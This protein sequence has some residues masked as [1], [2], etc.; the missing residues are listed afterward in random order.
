[1]VI[2]MKKQK[3]ICGMTAAVLTLGML[4]GC[5][6]ADYDRLLDQ[7]S[8]VTVTVWHYYNGVQ[9]T[10][11]DEMVSRFNN[12]VGSEKGIY[13][14]AFSKNSVS[15]LSGSVLAAVKEEP[16]A[17]NAPNIFATYVETAYQVDQLGKLADLGKYF[18][19]D[20]K[21]EYIEEY[22]DEGTFGDALVIF[23][24]AKC[25]EVMM[26][27]LT[28]WEGFAQA[29]G[30]TYDDL[31][32]WE[33]LTETAGKYYDYTDAKTPEIPNDGKAF[34]GRDAVANYM[35][36]GARQL[37][38]PF[39]QADA[40]GNVTVSADHDML[41]K[42][43]TNFYVPYVKGWFT[44]ESRF[45]SD[46]AKIGAVIALVCSTT[47]AAYYPTEVTVNDDYTYPIENVV[48]KV[49]NFEGTEPYAVQ[50]GAGMSVIKAEE[51][52]EYA[53]AVF[54]KWF[55][56]EER[57]IG[58]SVNSGYLPVKK[59][60]NRYDKIVSCEEAEGIGETMLNTFSAA[61]EEINTCTLYTSPPYEQSAQVRDFIGNTIENA[62]KADQAAA[63]ERILAGE[64]REAVLAEYTDDA[65][66]ERFYT[67][68]SAGL[69]AAAG[70]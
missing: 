59:S 2:K 40:E 26:L 54:L 33:S 12:T 41:K 8:P 67:E 3:A 35:M 6:G 4:S 60:A 58:F 36:I 32:T 57:N 31:A 19:E 14:E 61:I 18:T 51:K 34:F 39:A 7:A 25:T 30:V 42:L 64:D 62:A 24:T 46:D 70:Q 11:F 22:L 65:A 50:Q 68:F 13:V 38:H 48:L 53:C 15:E 56:E 16:G 23:P 63:R 1:M 9:Q 29:A 45:R 52:T 10:Q 69:L 20:E 44:A 28:D 55:T 66:F 37:G 43:W 21:S 5:G 49:P 17:E 47:G 27:N